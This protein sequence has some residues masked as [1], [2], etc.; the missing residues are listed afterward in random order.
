[1]DRRKSKCG[2]KGLLYKKCPR[3]SV[4]VARGAREDRTTKMKG[5]SNRKKRASSRICR[6]GG[7]SA[8]RKKKY[9][10][11]GGV[12]RNQVKS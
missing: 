8:R 1:M 9:G 6:G 3:E 5:R 2:S 10:I 12:E 4:L 11:K 7:R